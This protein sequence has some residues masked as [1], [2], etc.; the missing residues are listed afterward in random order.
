[1]PMSM[2]SLQ[3]Q[4]SPEKLQSNWSAEWPTVWKEGDFSVTLQTVFPQRPR[5][6]PS[7]MSSE[8]RIKSWKP[9][10]I[11]AMG[12]L[13]E[14]GGT[15]WTTPHKWSKREAKVNASYFSKWSPSYLFGEWCHIPDYCPKHKQTHTMNKS[16]ES[17][18]TQ[19]PLKQWQRTVAASFCS[20]PSTFN[21]FFL[22]PITM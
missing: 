4:P 13:Q 1:M 2:L 8:V 18:M 9:G 12:V 17:T 15:I 11:H 6:R 3:L 20:S 7:C 10:Q 19:K 5:Q 21:R 14:H 22:P 16:S